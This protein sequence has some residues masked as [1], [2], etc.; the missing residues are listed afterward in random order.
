L[1]TF[2]RPIINLWFTPVYAVNSVLLNT[3]YPYII[4]S[5]WTT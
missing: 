1:L 4:P 2:G 3:V 5:Q